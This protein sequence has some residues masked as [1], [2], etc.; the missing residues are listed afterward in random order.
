MSLH[1]IAWVVALG[2]IAWGVMQIILGFIIRR[3]IATI[4]DRLEVDRD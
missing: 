2:A 1:A 4:D 3:W